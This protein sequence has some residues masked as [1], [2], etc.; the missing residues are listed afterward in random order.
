MESDVNPIQSIDT[1]IDETS[2]P[3]I[4]YYISCFKKS[5]IEEAEGRWQ[6]AGNLKEK[7]N[8]PSKAK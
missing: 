1:P 3:P 4:S 8:R 5:L 7:N 6:S 2:K